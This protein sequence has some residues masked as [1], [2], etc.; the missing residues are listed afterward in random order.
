MRF[1]QLLLFLL[2][3]GPLAHATGLK[4][5]TPK[6]GAPVLA[7]DLYLEV[8]G[9]KYPTFSVHISGIKQAVQWTPVDNHK[10]W[11]THLVLPD[12]GTN[13]YQTL[14]VET[15]CGAI[16]YT[17]SISVRRDLDAEA[18]SKRVYDRA[19]RQLPKSKWNRNAAIGLDGLRRFAERCPSVETEVLTRAI[20]FYREQDKKYF[21]RR[22]DR[23]ELA[24]PSL[25][26]GWITEKY[27]S[28]DF[29]RFS[30]ALGY[31]AT[32]KRN[33]VG[34]FN[35]MGTRSPLSGIFPHVTM[36][37]SLYDYVYPALKLGQWHS[38][39]ALVEFARQ[40]AS[41]F[42]KKL[43]KPDRSSYFVH[44]LHSKRE[45]QVAPGLPPEKGVPL[46]KGT[47]WLRGNALAALSLLEVLE[48]TPSDHPLYP[49]LR[50]GFRALAYALSIHQM[51]NGLWDT[52]VD[53]PGAGYA[54][55]SGSAIAGYALLRGAKLGFLPAEFKDSGLRV[56]RGL[57]SRLA[58][59]DNNQ[60]T[61]TGVSGL[62]LPTLD[63]LYS[64]IMRH[65]DRFE[66]NG[67]F[68]TLASEVIDSCDF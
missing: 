41:T 26:L 6:N 36:V 9:C 25:T 65:D 44:A 33:A 48:A 2:T 10:R 45:V 27:P 19:I 43:Q 42:V 4:I 58:A 40:Q 29:K 17:Q 55:S 54:E 64:L 32:E 60:M 14:T 7:N 21:P 59:A 49:L 24:A 61:L 35:T 1:Y 8:E 50:K 5:I 16:E 57:A 20:Q 11:S 39:P 34:L 13:L 15:S 53:R 38:T 28:L 63:S 56:F 62:T 68:L 51:P 47:K 67:A 3:L 22:I 12:P 23:T 30:Q 52:L 31:F 18:I 66:G 37:E 46:F